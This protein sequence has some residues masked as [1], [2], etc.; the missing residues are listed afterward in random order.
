MIWMTFLNMLVLS[1]MTVISLAALKALK[2]HVTL[3]TL[4]RTAKVMILVQAVYAFGSFALLLW[5]QMGYAAFIVL[6]L[7][8][9]SLPVRWGRA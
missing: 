2:P 6:P 1:V 3:E 7:L 8:M 4:K 9:L 5:E